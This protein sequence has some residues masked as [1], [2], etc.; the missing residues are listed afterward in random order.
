MAENKEMSRAAQMSTI[1][2]AVAV[3]GAV[4]GGLLYEP[5]LDGMSRM[6]KCEYRSYYK[7]RGGNPGACK[8]QELQSSVRYL[9]SR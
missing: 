1:V 5:N 2:G 4:V 9:M 8:D 3:V 6:E 7:N